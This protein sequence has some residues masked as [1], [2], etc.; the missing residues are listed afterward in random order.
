MKRIFIAIKVEA[1]IELQRM[2]AN[3]KAVLGNEN[4][5]W[6]DIRNIHVT[7]AFLGDTEEKKIRS[8]AGVIK[9]KCA[10]FGDFEFTISGT[11]VFRNFRDPR[12]IWAGINPQEELIRLGELI[13][14]ALRQEDFDLDDKPFRPHITLG[15]IKNIRDIQNLKKVLAKYSYAELQTVSVKEVILF[16]SILKQAGP[17]YKPLANFPL[18]LNLKH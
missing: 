5:K 15:R 10:G 2:T 1:G 6:A 8:L 4:I 13:V 3:L 17:V 11:G 18:K 16:E 12:V 9:E 14:D 7:L